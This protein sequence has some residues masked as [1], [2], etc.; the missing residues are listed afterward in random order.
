MARSTNA[1]V[2]VQVFDR[3]DP[4]RE[5]WDDLLSRAA[6][7][8][9]FLRRDAV[10]AW[11][12][13]K[14]AGRR[15]RIWVAFV[16][17]QLVAALP[18]VDELG[19]ISLLVVPDTTER[20][21]PLIAQGHQAALD[22]IV[23]RIF[24]QRRLLRLSVK[25]AAEDDPAIL[26]LRSAVERLGC[27]VDVGERFLSPYLI[28]DDN[29]PERWV[30]ALSAR[31]RKNIRRRQRV[32][33]EI[34]QLDIRRLSG[35]DPQIFSALASALALEAAGW[36]GQAGTATL[37][38]PATAAYLEQLY[39]A[40]V[41]RGVLEL[42]ELR[43]GDQLAAFMLLAREGRVVNALKTSFAP[44]FSRGSPGIVLH[45]HEFQRLVADPSVGQIDMLGELTTS[46][47]DF[48]PKT[49]AIEHLRIF[50]PGIKGWATRWALCRALPE[51][52][53]LRSR[54]TRSK[55][56]GAT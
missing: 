30:G 10:E 4:L 24:V 5:Q 29:D 20:S 41:A 25:N 54:W 46:K 33:E 11:L 53:R 44:D 16:E 22:A 32:L 38:K 13:H 31:F 15:L 51:L 9:F 36:K 39:R 50:A 12:Q 14:L 52:R 7:P 23:A 19:G 42:I 6:Y 45:Y 1:Q 28:A 21:A 37:Q 17:G 56:P 3:I 35:D 40:Q 26:A 8:H 47:A 18:V 43:C 49:R 34:G 27:V 55:A 48:M 2:D